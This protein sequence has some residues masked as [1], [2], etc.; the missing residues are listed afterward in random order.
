MSR[1]NRL[2]KR[3]LQ[4]D[5]E[6][7]AALQAIVDYNPSNKDFELAK[8]TESHQAMV[9]D[10][11]DEIQ[12]H[13]V[14]NASSDKATNSERGFHDKILGAKNQVKAQYGENSD[15]YASLGMKK[16]SEYKRGRR[17]GSNNAV[18]KS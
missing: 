12:K 14:A 8:V 16:K 17:T 5:R 9:T 11:T 2:N 3:V 6:A 13:A 18:N 7:Y 15:E 4:E 1:Q 10:Q